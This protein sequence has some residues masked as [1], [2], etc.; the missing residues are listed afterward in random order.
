MKEKN[1]YLQLFIKTFY[2]S[3]FTFGGGFVIIS[4]MQKIFVEKLHWLNENEM[5]D[6]VSIAQSAPGVVAVNASIL[7][8]YHI[9][10]VLGS[11]VAILGTVMPPMIIIT[12]ITF[13]YNAFRSNTIISAVLKGMQ[14]G[15][16]AVVCDVAINMGKNVTKDRDALSI[17]VLLAS[18][19]AVYFYKVSVG[20][21]IPICGIIGAFRAVNLAKKTKREEI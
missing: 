14:S 13:F 6:Y 21:V 9:G 16:A 5:M 10:G 2:I 19:V 17:F 3:A 1:K 18:F 8:G 11:A 15:V 12:I 7:V 20:F 4:L